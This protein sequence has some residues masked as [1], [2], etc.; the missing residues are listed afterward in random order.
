VI[1]VYT[2]A[3]GLN[4]AGIVQLVVAESRRRVG[5]TSAEPVRRVL[6]QP[7]DIDDMGIE[8][9]GEPFF[10]FAM[11]L[12]F[13]IGDGFEELAMAPRTAD[14]FLRA[15]ALGF[16]QARIKNARF[17]IDQTFDL[18]RVF[19]T[20]AEVIE[21]LQRLRSDIFEHVAESGLACIEKVAGPSPGRD[22]ACS[23]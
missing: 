18:D 2:N 6:G 21:I 12:V 9:I 20:V 8:V 16:D 1:V 4:G 5:A 17:R 22:R 13:G 19:P 7:I 14:V 23:I 15:T 11:A 3:P 10:E